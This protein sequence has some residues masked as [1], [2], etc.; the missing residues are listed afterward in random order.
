MKRK[1]IIY[2]VAGVL[3][4]LSAVVYTY[5]PQLGVA[6]G[7]AAKKICTCTYETGRNQKEIEQNDLYFSVLPMVTNKLNEAQKS[8]T[9]TLWGLYPQTAIYKTGL[10][11]V[12]L[13]GEDDYHVEAPQLSTGDN[14]FLFPDK[15]QATKGLNHTLLQ[16]AID[17]EFN[18]DDNLTT[19]QTTSILVIHNDTLVA[20]RYAPPFDR[21]MSQL[22]WSMTKSWMNAYIG[23]LV[24]DSL[25]GINKSNLFPEWQDERK[26]ITLKNLLNMDS[27]LQWNED[28]KTVSDATRM[29][30]FSEDVSAIAL[31]K[32]LNYSPGTHWYYSSGTTNLISKYIRNLL[33]KETDYLSYLKNRLFNKL[34]M[35]SAFIETDESGLLI[36]SSYGY[37]TPRDWA[38]FGL[39][40]LHDGIWQGERILPEG[41]VNFTKTE[42]KDSKGKYGAQFWLNVNGSQYPDAPGD[43][44]LAD[45]FLGQYVFIIP[46]YNVV[47]V[48]MGT[49][50]A[51]FDEN[52]FLKNILA[53]IPHKQ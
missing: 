27:G 29:L 14:P 13:Q 42:V 20:E 30:Y 49:G 24:K 19:K 15:P 32:P 12:L 8:V 31:S 9:S 33:G 25:T 4:L 36:G 7:Y 28:Y 21:N 52:Q 37:A 23:L 48:R 38:K 2:L 44:F 26:E 11:C 53:A 16:D 3:L 5:Y 35:T 34:G 47:I 45:G 51:G 18:S 17:R 40:Y 41:W 10:G 1:L 50:K 39:L 46:S 43:I 6:T 22:G